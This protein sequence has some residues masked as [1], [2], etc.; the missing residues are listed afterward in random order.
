MSSSSAIA[1]PAGSGLNSIAGQARTPEARK[2]A[3]KELARRAGVSRDFFDSWEITCT[4]D[5]TTISLPPAGSRRVYFEHAPEKFFTQVTSGQFPVARAGYLRKPNGSPLAEDLILPFCESPL[6]PSVPLFQTQADGSFLCRMDLL[7]SVLLT[8]SR[9]EENICKTRDEHGRFPASASL[10]ARHEFLER[11]IVDECAM[12]FQQVLN[13][14]IP[15][16]RP[17]PPG[18]RAKLTHDID[19]VGIPIQP[20]ATIGHTL[21]RRRPASTLRDLL[22]TV[23]PIKPAELE[24]VRKL[25]HISVSRRLHSSFYWKGSPRTPMDEGYDPFHPKIQRVILDLKQQ[26]FEVGVHPGYYTFA[27]RS[28]LASEVERLRKALGRAYLG[29]RQHYLRWS[30]QTWE[31]WEACGL[32]YDSTVG[33]ADQIGFRAGTSIPFRPWSFAM[34]RELNLIEIPLLLMDCTPVKY[35]GLRRAE[36]LERIRRCIQQVERVGGV[37]TM[38]WHNVPLMDPDYDG[39]YEPILDMLAGSKPFVV[40]ENADGLW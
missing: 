31:D 4:A 27:S 6:P 14:L 8:L 29:G 37:F 12:A 16:W 2:Y 23:S 19:N 1:T 11:P 32:A 7:S 17:E 18:L 33:F 5:R 20:R 22:A 28:E 10:A 35:M 39:W 36:G 3:V 15:S 38:L 9:V 40:P 24:L 21:K 34:N 26:G 13:A 30:P 25:A